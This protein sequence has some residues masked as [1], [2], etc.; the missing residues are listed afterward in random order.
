MGFRAIFGHAELQFYCRAY[1]DGSELLFYRETIC[2]GVN[3]D[4]LD[5]LII[6]ICFLLILP[7]RD[8][9]IL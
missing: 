1:L 5:R 9:Y 3:K 7:Y 4:F 8:F 6:S 2:L